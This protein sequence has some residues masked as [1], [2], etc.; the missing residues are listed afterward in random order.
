M[1]RE[2]TQRSVTSLVYFSAN[3]DDLAKVVGGVNL[4]HVPMPDKV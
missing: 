4:L 3:R 2:D 1:N